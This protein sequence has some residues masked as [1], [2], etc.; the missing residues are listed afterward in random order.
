MSGAVV[1][2]P[3]PLFV[4]RTAGTWLPPLFLRVVRRGN[5][6]LVHVGHRGEESNVTDEPI[7]DAFDGGTEGFAVRASSVKG[8]AG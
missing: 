8:A 1:G 4:L 7:D 3:T 6:L 5:A 2:N